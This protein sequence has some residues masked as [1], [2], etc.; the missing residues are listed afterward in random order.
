MLDSLQRLLHKKDFVQQV[1]V[2]ILTSEDIDIV[3]YGEANREIDK[4]GLSMGERQLYASALLS[5]LVS[6]SEIDFPV[7]IDSPMQKFDNQHAQNII[8]HF[9]PN[10]AKQVVIFPLLHKELTENEYKLLQSN[11]CRTFLINNTSSDSSEFLETE[12]ND[13][14]TKYNYISNAN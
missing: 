4:S 2:D 9:Y 3:L 11:V 5:S 13:F 6:E 1:D 8:R 12:P 7:F 10:V 14:F